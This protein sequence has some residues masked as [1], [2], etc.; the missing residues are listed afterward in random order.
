M[1]TY[2]SNTD[3]RV[4]K[5]HTDLMGIPINLRSIGRYSRL[6]INNFVT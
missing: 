4:N 1:I 6:K 3:M 2:Y 5:S